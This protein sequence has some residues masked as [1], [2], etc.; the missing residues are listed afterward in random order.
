MTQPRVSHRKQ[1]LVPEKPVVTDE[2]S[3]KGTFVSV[4]LLAAFIIVVWTVIFLLF[5]SRN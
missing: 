3:L 1:D 4:M 2:H 5:L